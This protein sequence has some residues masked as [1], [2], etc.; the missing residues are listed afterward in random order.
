M[1]HLLSDPAE[2]SSCCCDLRSKWELIQNVS[3]L[4]SFLFLSAVVKGR[5]SHNNLVWEN[6]MGFPFNLKYSKFH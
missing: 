3:S 4:G 6:S 5:S 2:R 1:F